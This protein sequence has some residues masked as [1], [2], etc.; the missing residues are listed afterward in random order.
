MFRHLLVLLVILTFCSGLSFSVST[1]SPS[2]KLTYFDIEGAAEPIRLALALSGTPFEDERVS[3]PDWAALKPT[4]PYGQLPLLTVDGKIFAQSKAML[5][6]VGSTCSKTLYPAD[7]L[8]DIEEAVGLV[9][10]M[11]GVW[12]PAMSMS[13]SPTKYGYSAEFPKTEEGL[14]KVLEMRTTFVEKQLPM[15]LTYFEKLIEKNG[16]KWLVAGDEPTIADCLAVATLRSFTRGHIDGVPTTCLDTHP[17][18][19]EYIKNFCALVPIQGRYNNGI[20]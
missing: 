8:L 13:M 16:G 7:K 15:Y 18:V 17:K 14:K 3:F 12:T 20:F 2:V 19:V 11:T 6:W 1:M 5:R 4:T 10:D 9:E